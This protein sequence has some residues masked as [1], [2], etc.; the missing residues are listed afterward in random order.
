MLGFLLYIIATIL[1]LPLTGLNLMVLIWK[2][3]KLFSTLGG[4]FFN[5][6]I[7]IDVFSNH[8]FRTLWN[9]ILR[10]RGG[11]VFGNPHETISSALGKNQRDKTLSNPGKLICWV[12]DSL[13]K[14][15]CKKSINNKIMAEQRIIGEKETPEQTELLNKAQQVL[16]DGKADLKIE[17]TKPKPRGIE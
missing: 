4:Y 12:L 15:H 2:R 14:N 3:K 9:T 6:A 8:N 1:F 7:D 10:K 5:G 11:Y 16:D 13:D 17:S